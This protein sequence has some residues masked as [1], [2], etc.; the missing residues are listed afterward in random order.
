M[1]DVSH[2]T[3]DAMQETDVRRLLHVAYMEWVG[4][5]HRF[6]LVYTDEDIDKAI[7]AWDEAEKRYN[8]LLRIVK[9][10]RD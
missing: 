5:Q 9:S 6:H 4:A 2:T 1:Q 3:G 10:N 8:A 7:F